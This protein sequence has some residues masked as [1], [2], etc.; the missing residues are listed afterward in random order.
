MS[1]TGGHRPA[2]RRRPVGEAV[3]DL[4]HGDHAVRDLPAVEALGEREP[5]VL[6][7]VLHERVE[8]LE[9]VERR[10]ARVEPGSGDHL[11]PRARR[12]RLDAQAEVGVE[13][14][15]RRV[16]DLDRLPAPGRPLDADRRRLA[17]RDLEAVLVRE[18]RLDH[19]PLHLAVERDR[20]L[21]RACRPGGRRSAGP[22]LRAARARRAAAGRPRDRRA[23]RPT[24]TSAE[25]S[26]GRRRG[27]ARRASRRS[28]SPRGPRA[29]RS[30]PRCTASRCTA[31]PSA[32]TRTAVTLPASKRSRTVT[33]PEKTPRVRDPVALG[34][35]LDLEDA[36]RER[37]VAVPGAA[38]A[39]AA[40]SRSSPPPR[41]RR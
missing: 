2:P 29:S 13:R 35:A 30:R 40:R 9:R 15:R 16:E 5:D 32:K 3:R 20:D 6:A 23:R 22:A 14:V 33:A 17:E 26:G 25:R 19:L 36:G 1:R 18:R 10:V 38:R 24:R 39:G 8:G 37:R 11:D 31:S 7:H 41:R 28:G 4:R 34:P 27:A 12:R 21:R